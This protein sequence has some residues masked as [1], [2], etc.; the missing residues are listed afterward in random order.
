MAI[1]ALEIKARDLLDTLALNTSSDAAVRQV[2]VAAWAQALTHDRI[3]EL[4]NV[5]NGMT[6]NPGSIKAALVRAVRAGV[7]RSRVKSGQRL[8]EV[9]L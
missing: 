5:L 2:F 6:F 9:V 7:L 8:Y 3:V 1:T 4:A